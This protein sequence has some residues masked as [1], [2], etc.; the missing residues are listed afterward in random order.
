MLK[1]LFARP[2]TPALLTTHTPEPS[3]LEATDSD[4]EKRKKH[5][6]NIPFLQIRSTDML[7]AIRQSLEQDAQM[8]QDKAVQVSEIHNSADGAINAIGALTTNART[9]LENAQQ[10]ASSAEHLSMASNQIM[11]LVTDIQSVSQRT[12]LLS[13]NASIEAARA[14]EAGKG[15]AVVAGEVRNLASQTHQASEA[16]SKLASDI[17]THVSSILEAAEVTRDSA[18][19]TETTTCDVET[20]VSDITAKSVDMQTFIQE[21]SSVAFINSVK[22]D[23]AC[24][25]NTVYSAVI[26]RDY[27]IALSKHTHCRLGRWY[28]EGPGRAFANKDAYQKL[29]HPHKR[30][31][32]SGAEA[33]R[34]ARDG[35]TAGA[36]NAL[37]EMESASLEVVRHLDALIN[38]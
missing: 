21:Y 36:E 8:L 18:Q 29:D 6:A 25:K 24:F 1:T 16:I 22:L 34:L 2:S 5:L 37:A 11:S 9:V 17:T 7:S 12:N 31:H 28:F 30:V 4:G 14:G 26:N 33:L 20:Q 10:N 32:Q 3:E 35:D 23:H 38:G 13:L 27:D 15:F 19:T